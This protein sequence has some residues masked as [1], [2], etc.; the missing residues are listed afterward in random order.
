M[1]SSC[2]L[3][4]EKI[5]GTVHV[6]DSGMYNEGEVTGDA[7]STESTYSSW[8]WGTQPGV[9]GPN[10]LTDHYK[11]AMSYPVP[12]IDFDQVEVD[13]KA[14]RDDAKNNGE[15]D[16]YD[17]SPSGSKGYH[18]VLKTDSYDLYKVTKYSSS[19]L[20]ITQE[21]LLGNHLYPEDG[22]II[23]EDNTWINGTINGQKITIIAADP[24]QS[25]NNQKRIVIRI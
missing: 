15:G 18:V 6:N 7:S 25:G 22:I 4:R 12:R 24:E 13:I 16:Y 19:D 10:P 23:L 3:G 14:I 8:N 11:G 9:S 2:G 5:T 17:T 21:S 1:E 20:N